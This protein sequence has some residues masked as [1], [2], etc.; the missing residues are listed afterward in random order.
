MWAVNRKHADVVK[1]LLEA[2]ANVNVQSNDGHTPM[3][4]AR[5]EAMRE[6]IHLLEKAGALQQH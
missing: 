1:S 3:M 5:S 4:I 2:G 6:I